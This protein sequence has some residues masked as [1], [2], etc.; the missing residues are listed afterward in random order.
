MV[1][2]SD[3][4]VKFKAVLGDL[5]HKEDVYIK[6]NTVSDPKILA[7]LSNKSQAEWLRKHEPGLVPPG[8]PN[9]QPPSDHNVATVFEFCYLSEPAFR[10][11][12]LSSYDHHY[13]NICGG[14]S[15]DG[16]IQQDAESL[17]D[18]SDS[19]YEFIVYKGRGSWGTIDLHA[20]R[21]V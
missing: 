5:K 8:N 18:S 21:T 13:C 19:D 12:V 1:R 16:L 7:L 3:N 11:H 14:P 10:H 2:R 20:N 4:S 17:G 6:F 15:D 9:G